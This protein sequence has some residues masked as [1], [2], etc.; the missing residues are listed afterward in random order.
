MG[1]EWGRRWMARGKRCKFLRDENAPAVLGKIVTFRKANIVYLNVDS[2][3][4]S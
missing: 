2:L 4:Y 1:V 3:G